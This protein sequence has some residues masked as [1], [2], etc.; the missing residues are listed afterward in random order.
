MNLPVFHHHPHFDST[1]PD[2]YEQFFQIP[3]MK[4]IRTIQCI[5]FYKCY[6]SL[7]PVID[8]L[9]ATKINC[10]IEQKHLTHLDKKGRLERLLKRKFLA[11]IC[12]HVFFSQKK[13][14]PTYTH[15][16]AKYLPSNIWKSQV[17]PKTHIF[18]SINISRKYLGK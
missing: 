5:I 11:N 8:R 7:F 15:R 16:F 9:M 13:K 4:R 1:I 10:T 17:L 18:E 2:N 14:I 6:N 12:I 3:L